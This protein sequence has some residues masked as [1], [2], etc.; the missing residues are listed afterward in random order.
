MS[1]ERCSAF[2]IAKSD[3]KNYGEVCRYLSNYVEGSSLPARNK[4]G[5]A[6][7]RECCGIVKI[8]LIF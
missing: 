4:L 3:V 2:G 5:L 1:G 7:L 8:I 6:G